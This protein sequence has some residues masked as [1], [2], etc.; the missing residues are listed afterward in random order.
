M[1]PWSS[2]VDDGTYELRFP[3]HLVSGTDTSV[4][5]SWSDGASIITD[6]ANDEVVR[7]VIVLS[8]VSISGSYQLVPPVTHTL[9]VSSSPVSGIPIT[10]DGYQYST[11]TQALSLLEGSNHVVVPP[12]NVA[13][14]S[15]IYTFV[16]WENGSTSPQRTITVLSDMILSFTVQLQVTP[17][18]QGTLE[19]HA[20]L[21]E[22]EIVAPYEVVGETAG[23]TPATVTLYEGNYTV[24]VTYAERVITQ[25]A[26][27]FASQ[28]LRLDFQFSTVTPPSHGFG[29]LPLIL[30]AGLMIGL[31]ALSS[32]KSNK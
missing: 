32:G 24:R 10:V 12:S 27:V 13:V 28:P 31:V 30:G 26:A 4:F 23:N 20:F 14:G 15:D 19:V 16:S 25:Q 1:T 3:R 22:A 2:L 17:P 11:P 29:S 7:T 9:V 8:D 18:E 5:N 21:D 6:N